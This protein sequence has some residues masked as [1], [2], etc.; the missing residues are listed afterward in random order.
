MVCVAGLRWHRAASRTGTQPECQPGISSLGGRVHYA[1]TTMG[2]S[3]GASASTAAVWRTCGSSGPDDVAD[4]Y[5]CA[6]PRTPCKQV[7]RPLVQA[8]AAVVWRAEGAE[9]ARAKCQ[10][11]RPDVCEVRE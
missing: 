8:R 9:R 11:H 4:G 10:R 6:V 1:L 3:C 7:T 2:D 5:P